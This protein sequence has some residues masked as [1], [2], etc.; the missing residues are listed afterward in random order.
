M[1]S[2]QVDYP[3]I[4]KAQRLTA[5]R[6]GSVVARTCPSVGNTGTCATY[7]QQHE[8][9]RP[10]N[11]QGHVAQQPAAITMQEEENKHGGISSP[12]L[13]WVWDTGAARAAARDQDGDSMKKIATAVVSPTDDDQR[14]RKKTTCRG[15]RSRSSRR[16]A[17]QGRWGGAVSRSPSCSPPPPPPRLGEDTGRWKEE[18]KRSASL[19]RTLKDIDEASPRVRSVFLLFFT[20]YLYRQ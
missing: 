14:G 9:Q 10:V 11:E 6:L 16:G 20:I 12:P 7:Q 17:G 3:A 19:E 8:G 13:R 1:S 18:T 5:E 2:R 4:A 15:T